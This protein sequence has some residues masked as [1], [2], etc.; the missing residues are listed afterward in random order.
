MY[1][2]SQG[3]YRTY[4][5]KSTVQFYFYF[6]CNM[7]FSDMAR[8]VFLARTRRMLCGFS[9]FKILSRTSTMALATEITR[10]LDHARTCKPWTRRP[11][12]PP[13]LLL[14]Q[15]GPCCIFPSASFAQHARIP[16]HHIH[17]A[18]TTD[19]SGDC[20]CTVWNPDSGNIVYIYLIF[21]VF[22]R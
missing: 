6:L 16:T 1:V 3:G 5:K 22:C 12:P 13:L 4:E 7:K 19:F 9:D 8:Y 17:A 20:R 14:K 18:S 10:E 2:I 15:C 21:H 11:P